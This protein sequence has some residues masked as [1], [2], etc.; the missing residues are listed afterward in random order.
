MTRVACSAIDLCLLA[1][2]ASSGVA[3]AC[4]PLLLLVACAGK[5][6]PT[7]QQT[8]TFSTFVA[9]AAEAMELNTPFVS[10]RSG[11]VLFDQPQI[12]V[13][14]FRT[15]GQFWPRPT[16]TIHISELFL[17]EAAPLLLRHAAAH[18]KCHIKKW[19]AGELAV[20]KCAFE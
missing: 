18:E 1:I 15:P 5:P 6:M 19:P 8:Q 3:W 13:A 17:A 4:L 10:I 12:E 20:E 14:T 16:Y 7:E 11:P 9:E 2:R